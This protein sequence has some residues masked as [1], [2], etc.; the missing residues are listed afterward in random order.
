[1]SSV[2][3]IKDVGVYDWFCLR[4]EKPLRQIQK[5]LELP[6]QS[7]LSAPALIAPA[8]VPK[9]QFQSIDLMAQDEE[10]WILSFKGRDQR[11]LLL[12]AA[13]A[14]NEERLSLR[15]ARAHTWGNQVEDVFSVRPFGEVSVLIA[16]LKARFVT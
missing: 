11:G 8:A 9:V 6:P 14:L 1:M 2:H 7:S 12:A 3:T 10:E 15:W 4:T 13:H 5:W 16:R